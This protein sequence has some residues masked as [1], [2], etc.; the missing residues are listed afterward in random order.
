[1]TAPLVAA[2][3][4][5][6][7]WALRALYPL[8]REGA[9]LTWVHVAMSGSWEGHPSGP[10]TFDRKT[11]EQCVAN[12]DAQANPVPLD[13]E[14]ATEWAAQAPAAGWVHRLKIT[15]DGDSCSLWALVELTDKA[16]EYVRSGE[17][18][19]SSGVFNFGS[20]DRRSGNDIGCRMTS[21]ALTNTPFIDSQQPIRLSQK[22][23]AAAPK[24]LADP[25]GIA[26]IGAARTKYTRASLAAGATMAG[27]KVT[28]AD[29]AELVKR[30]QGE[31]V[32]LDQ[33][34]AILTGIAAERGET[35][36]ETDE[37][38]APTDMPAPPMAQPPEAYA[39]LSD[40]Q[41]KAFA[42]DPKISEKIAKLVREGKPAD[43]AAAIAY[44]MQRRGE[45][46][47]TPTDAT[48]LADA[49]GAPAPLAA[50][51]APMAPD[52]A[53]TDPAVMVASKLME[54]TGLDA[55]AILAALEQNGDA[56][57]AAFVGGAASQAPVPNAAPLSDRERDE[58]KLAL[59]VRDENAKALKSENEAMRVELGAVRK[60]EAERAVDRLLKEGRCTDAMKPSLLAMALSDRKR[61]DE[62]AA[63]LPQ[64]IPMAP[65]ALSV[66][67]PV[68]PNAGISV[69]EADP[70]V[71]QL[72]QNLE[73]AGVR[74]VKQNDAVRAAVIKRKNNGKPAQA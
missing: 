43:E 72:R 46:S 30:I 6:D 51:S 52:P 34:E 39:D 41:R 59:A 57:K 66:T 9:P 1:M 16:A 32:T 22:A 2:I 40:D 62:F 33:V 73:T 20:I 17:Y 24:R 25:A 45:L 70:F 55:A 7:R 23:I 27:A 13:Y 53:Q 21:L 11:F 54:L 10:F 35:L 68:D 15:E 4:L 42:Q 36:G 74:G 65:H 69:D 37:E 67:P 56:I 71:R 44:D 64:V 28:K 63:T 29:L 19:Y 5:G 26:S 58:H 31:D 60:V 3:R 49:P 12:F 18:R 47:D 8:V 50:P 14:H 48:A 38:E 61:F